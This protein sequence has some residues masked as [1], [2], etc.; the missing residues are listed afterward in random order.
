VGVYGCLDCLFLLQNPKIIGARKDICLQPCKDSARKKKSVLIKE[1]LS[2][3]F[4][5]GLI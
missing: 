2:V 3:H 5:L 1:C 4:F